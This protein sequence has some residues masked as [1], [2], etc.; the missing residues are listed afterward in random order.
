MSE[1]FLPGRLTKVFSAINKYY[2][3]F[4]EQEL[5]AWGRHDLGDLMLAEQLF[6]RRN[7]WTG[8]WSVYE[9]STRR[10]W[11]P[12]ENGASFILQAPNAQK[13]AGGLEFYQAKE[14]LRKHEEKPKVYQVG[15]GS[16]YSFKNG[17]PMFMK[18]D[19]PEKNDWRNATLISPRLWA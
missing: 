2:L 1:K 15:P 8:K 14:M 7:F 11:T 13:I 18:Q 4:N 10:G 5:K 6:M 17:A 16:H 9:L 12:R 19:R 3:P